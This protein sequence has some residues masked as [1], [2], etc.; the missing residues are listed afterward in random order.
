MNKSKLLRSESHLRTV[1]S[2]T[3]CL[4]VMWVLINI[5]WGSAIG[6]LAGAKMG[7]DK[8]FME[9]ISDILK[10]KDIKETNIPNS[11]FDDWYKSLPPEIHKD[12]ENAIKLKLQDINWF[13]VAL[14]VSAFTFAI[15]GFLYGFINKA[16]VTVGLIVILS[17]LTNNPVVRFPCTKNLDI[18][19]KFIIVAVAQFGICYL[20]GYLGTSFGR[21]RDT[22]RK[23][24]KGG[25]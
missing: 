13:V 6:I 15:V 1:I 21:K 25:L 17:F 20:F 11:N 10:S 22:R 2:Y 18:L 14:A 8:A 16:F 9:E 24:K 7:S 12:I 4:V 19:Q 23:K 3:I 5:T